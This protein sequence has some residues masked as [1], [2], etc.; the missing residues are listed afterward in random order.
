[1]A[2]SGLDVAKPTNN[3]KNGNEKIWEENETKKALDAAFAI[4]KRA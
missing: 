2:C 3:L 1:M 4:Q